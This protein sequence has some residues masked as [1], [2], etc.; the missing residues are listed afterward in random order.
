MK[1]IFFVSLL[2]LAS[3]AISAKPV[4][5]GYVDLGLPSGT[6]WKVQ[7]EPGYF[8]FR[9]AENRFGEKL[10]T[11]S[12]FEELLYNCSWK[13]MET[14][15][16]VTGPNDQQLFFPF[17]G[18][19]NCDEMLEGEGRLSYFWLQSGHVF[20]MTSSYKSVSSEPYCLSTSI[21]LVISGE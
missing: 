5:S 2:L 14:G 9:K 20:K 16:R 1:K 7:D 8:L 13:L 3:I 15:Y 18:Y 19:M 11:A 12:Q 6:L 17:H 10:P 21:R 4:P